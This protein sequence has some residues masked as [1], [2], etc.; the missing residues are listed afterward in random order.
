MFRKVGGKEERGNGRVSGKNIKKERGLSGIYVDRRIRYD[1]G[2]GGGEGGGGGAGGG[3]A[4]GR[5][6]GGGGGGGGGG[7][8]ERS[9]LCH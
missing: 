7:G 2:E 3:G 4:G 1:G 8:K 5:G 9:G 6:A